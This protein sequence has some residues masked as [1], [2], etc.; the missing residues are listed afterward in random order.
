MLS[1]SYKIRV[2]Y[3]DTDKMGFVHHSNYA[4]IYEN[5]RWETLRHF[6]I[7]YSEIESQ[8]IFMPV[9]N[10]DFKFIKP[11][12]YDDVLTVVTRI[13]ELPSV[14][15]NFAFELHNSSG[16]I[17]NTA[18]LSCAF[19]DSETSKVLRPPKILIDKLRSKIET[20]KSFN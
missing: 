17:I 2:N 5:A 15:M 3:S 14:K 8:G 16:K 6:G 20:L 11:A 1:Y 12:Y 10:M 13:S 9:I 19:I 7:P 18:T 4:K